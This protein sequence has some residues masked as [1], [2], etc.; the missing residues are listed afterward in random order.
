MSLP[1]HQCGVVAALTLHLHH[2]RAKLGERRLTEPSR[3][4]EAAPH[5]AALDRARA[6]AAIGGL[7]LATGGHAAALG[8]LPGSLGDPAAEG[9]QG[10]THRIAATGPRS[11]P[12]RFSGPI[13]PRTDAW[14]TARPLSGGCL[15]R[16]VAVRLEH[17]LG[18]P[19][20][21]E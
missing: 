12:P 7:G 16:H 11:A 18:H 6:G 14:L 9:F 8:G 10:W 21:A 20:A 1:L 17:A 19:V 5:R 3:A 15:S 2:Q 13:Y 4:A